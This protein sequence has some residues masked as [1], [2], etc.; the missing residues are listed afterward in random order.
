[1]SD[2]IDIH[3][4]QLPEKTGDI[5][6]T[7]EYLMIHDGYAL[8]KVTAEKLYE[9]F[10]QNY[11]ID[12]MVKTID[13]LLVIENNKYQ[14]LYVDLDKSTKLY[15]E[16][17]ND[18]NDKFLNDINNIRNL[19]SLINH[20]NNDIETLSKSQNN[21]RSKFSKLHE[22]INELD[23]TVDNIKNRNIIVEDIADDLNKSSEII[24]SA[25]KEIASGNVYLK[26]SISRIS[27]HEESNLRDKAEDISMNINV[28][29][30]RIVTIIDSLHHHN[31]SP[32]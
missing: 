29:Y 11:K 24:T 13:T 20:I 17:V 21:L 26:E 12:N 18:L 30:D 4:W 23:E 14:P 32:S 31:N 28:A 1:M 16:T 27:K 9:Y 6:K 25:K 5:N 15:E 22:K 3:I 10:G 2:I 19:E 8:K 7:K